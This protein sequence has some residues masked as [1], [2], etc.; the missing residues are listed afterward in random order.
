MK[1]VTCSGPTFAIGPGRSQDGLH[2]ADRSRGS[3]P[4][5]QTRPRVP[6]RVILGDEPHRVIEEIKNLCSMT[7]C[8]TLGEGRYPDPLRRRTRATAGSSRVK[9]SDVATRTARI[10]TEKYGADFLS[11]LPRSCLKSPF[12]TPLCRTWARPEHQILHQSIWDFCYSLL[13]LSG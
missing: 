4:H 6:E 12:H 9:A 10:E 8:S 2:L 3:V 11:V 1:P 7:W 13:S 5:P